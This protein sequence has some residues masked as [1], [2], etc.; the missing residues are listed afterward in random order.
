MQVPSYSM[1][2][3]KTAWNGKESFKL[4]PISTN[5]PYAEC[6]YDPESKVMVVIAKITKTALHMIPKL[7]PDGLPAIIQ[8]GLNAGK[9]KQE[10]KEISVFY[11]YYIEDVADMK[12]IIDNLA[13][14]CYDFK[15]QN[16]VVEDTVVTEEGEKSE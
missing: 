12:A 5:A 11:E 3:T 1:L 15:W 9:P 16:Y 13:V 2:L 7:D 10:R 8:K 4:I 14:N 6:I